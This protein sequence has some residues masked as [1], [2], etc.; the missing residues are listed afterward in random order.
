MSKGLLSKAGLAIS[1]FL[2]SFVAQAALSHISINSRQFELGQHPKLKLNIV[3]DKN[4]LSRVNFHLRQ[5][6][7]ANEVLEELMV[8]S[9]NG[10]MLYA[11]G[12]DDVKD[13]NAKLIVSEYK[14][15]SWRQHSVLPV[16]DA[17][18]IKANS[19]TEIKIEPSKQVNKTA[20]IPLVQTSRKEVAKPIKVAV[21]PNA[22]TSAKNINSDIGTSCMIERT[23][24]DTLW[25]IAS[26]YAKTWDTNVYG[27]MLA[28][29]EANPEAFSKGKIYL[30]KQDIHLT[31][32]TKNQLN[33]YLSKHEDMISFEELDRK[34][35]RN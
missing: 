27:V 29:F 13:P 11:I 2:F 24:T 35:R 20:P 21:E 32:P 1:L 23:N 7:G 18:F 12:V 33:Q 15:N 34:H 10:F 26:R 9:V 4:D 30:I 6:I 31:C 17:P 16:F 14:G 8:Q 28:I 19:Q 3:A 25:R 22:L 5:T